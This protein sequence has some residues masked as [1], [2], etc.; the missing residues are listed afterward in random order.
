MN[1]HMIELHTTPAGFF[2]ARV[3]GLTIEHAYQNLLASIEPSH[4]ATSIRARG[5]ERTFQCT[6]I[7]Y[8]E[9]IYHQW[10]K[11]TPQSKIKVAAL[12]GQWLFFGRM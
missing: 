8:Q 11:M 10:N 5:Y 1:P 9:W 4:P 2:W 6:D 12:P 7:D 3:S